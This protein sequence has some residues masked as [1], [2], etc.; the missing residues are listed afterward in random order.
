MTQDILVAFDLDQG[1]QLALARGLQLAEQHSGQ[2]TC[3]HVLDE[4]KPERLKE[5]EKR[6]ALEAMRSALPPARRDDEGIVLRVSEGSVEER[7]LEAAALQDVDM[8]VVGAPRRRA[9]AGLWLGSTVERLLRYGPHPVLIT[10]QAAEG[11]YHKLCLALDESASSR[12]ALAE[13][14]RLALL[15]P[16]T[17]L[18]AVHALRDPGRPLMAHAGIEGEAIAER[19]AGERSAAAARIDTLL[20]EAG[21]YQA[22]VI[23]REAEPLD[24]VQESVE[25]FDIELLILGTRGSTGV[26]RLLLGSTAETLIAEVDC[27]VLAIPADL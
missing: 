3:L 1:S 14:E 21:L 12:Q 22:S 5:E 9:I 16:E 25:H 17:S 8:I 4:R 10:R 11:P 13:A 27:D 2:L 26:K 6:Q 7:L 18:W 20:H 23:V 24:L 15:G 19:S